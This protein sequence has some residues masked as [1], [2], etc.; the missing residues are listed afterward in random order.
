MK[1]YIDPGMALILSEIR[2]L[3]AF[4]FKIPPI[5][6]ARVRNDA[7]TIA[8]SKG[9]PA[10][11][12]VEME[13]PGEHPMRARLYRPVVQANAPV[14]VFVHG[15]GWTFGSIDTHDGTMRNLAA[16]SGCAVFGF[17]YRLSPEHPF[18]AP[19]DDTCAAIAFVQAGGL[20]AAVDPSR[21]ALAG[22]S[23]GATLA[24]AAMLRARDE[25]GTLPSAAAL[26]YGCYA[27]IFDT[28]SHAAFG[29]GFLLTSVNMRWYWMNYLAGNL[30]APPA[31]AAPL[32]ARLEGL[33]PLHL[34]AA[35]LDPLRDDT[36][37]LAVRLA[38]A[39]VAFSYE[40]IP[41]VVHG[42]LRMSGRLAPARNLI[43][44]AGQF[45]QENLKATKVGG[46]QP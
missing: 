25:G 40:H 12:T 45:L 13:I 24:L 35:G 3:P 38:E 36:S 46:K 15:G 33:P 19:L 9:A 28:P 26:F 5:G 23:A 2:A 10:M 44:S 1:P 27:P 14:I 18:P 16:A 8:W 11:A 30:E 39:G 22:D 7:A 6:E 29:D 32:G 37:R 43:R 34:S 21:L 4:D 41:G 20:G 17:D 31:L 42:C